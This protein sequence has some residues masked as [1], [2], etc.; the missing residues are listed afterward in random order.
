MTL[1]QFLFFEGGYCTVIG[2]TELPNSGWAKDHPAQPQVA[3]LAMKVLPKIS[4]ILPNTQQFIGSICP[5]CQ[6]VRGI[7]E[8]SAST[9]RLYSVFKIVPKVKASKGF[10]G[11][12]NF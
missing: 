8:K 2:L 1:I 11:H 7:L 5:I 6:N 9:R 10:Y 3:S 12:R 4:Q